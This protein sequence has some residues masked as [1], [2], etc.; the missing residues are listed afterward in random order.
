M[1]KLIYHSLHPSYIIYSLYI[2]VSRSHAVSICLVY[3][4][5][6]FIIHLIYSAVKHRAIRIT[7]SIS[8]TIY[9]Y[10]ITLYAYGYEPKDN[11]QLIYYATQVYLPSRNICFIILCNGENVCYLF[12]YTNYELRGYVKIILLYYITQNL[13]FLNIVSFTCLH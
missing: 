11:L 2:N 12:L 5:S 6:R 10:N 4:F 9:T 7:R 8:V 13:L 3:L 1:C